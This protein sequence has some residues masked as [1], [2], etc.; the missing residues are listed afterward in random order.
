VFFEL[1]ETISRSGCDPVQQSGTS[2]Q[3]IVEEQPTSS[4]WL[5]RR[6]GGVTI[7]SS[8]CGGPRPVL[9]HMA[10]NLRWCRANRSQAGRDHGPSALVTRSGRSDASDQALKRPQPRRWPASESSA[11]NGGRKFAWRTASDRRR[12][13]LPRTPVLQLPVLPMAGRYGPAA[14]AAS[15]QDDFRVIRALL[16]EPL[17]QQV[18]RC[19]QQAGECA[20]SGTRSTTTSSASPAM[21]SWWTDGRGIGV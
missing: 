17:S 6:T 11:T 9:H 10:Y 16:L 19:Q 21:A 4:C 3:Q 1:R 2:T 20:A 15:G 18:R 5:R 8:V 12:G 7:A 13:L 14:I